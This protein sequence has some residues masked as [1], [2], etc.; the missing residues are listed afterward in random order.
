M[1][2]FTKTTRTRVLGLPIGR[3]RTT[4]DWGSVARVGAGVAAT[5]GAAIAAA[6][7]TD[8]LDELASASRRAMGRVGAVSDTVAEA[9]AGASGRSTGIGSMLGAFKALGTTDHDASDDDRPRGDDGRFISLDDEPE[10]TEDDR[11]ER[12]GGRD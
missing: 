5:A 3:A 7:R 6:R 2:P 12:V 11:R 1:R 4:T 8:P 9:R 10:S